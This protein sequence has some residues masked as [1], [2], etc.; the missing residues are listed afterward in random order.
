MRL[1]RVDTAGLQAMAGR[2]GA[3]VGELSGTVTPRGVGPSCEASAA[4]VAAAH[5][6]VAAF[7]AVLATRVGGHAAHVT[8]AGAGYLANEADAVRAM[9]AVAPSITGT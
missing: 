9:V 2:W 4:A 1:L 3:S 5:T 6:E 8:E 7:I